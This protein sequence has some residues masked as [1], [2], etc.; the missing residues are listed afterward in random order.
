MFKFSSNKNKCRKFEQ[1]YFL[2]EKPRRA[3][4]HQSKMNNNEPKHDQNEVKRTD[5]K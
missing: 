1:K 2:Q 5:E 3:N 4:Q